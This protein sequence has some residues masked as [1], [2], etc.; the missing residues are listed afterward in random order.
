MGIPIINYNDEKY[1]DFVV[2]HAP[3]SLFHIVTRAIIDQESDEQLKEVVST[4]KK[5]VLKPDSY[6]HRYDKQSHSAGFTIANI[7]SAMG[8][9]IEVHTPPKSCKVYVRC[10]N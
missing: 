9:S 7:A 3:D 1:R 4:N 8:H 6:R 2:V 5:E 10:N